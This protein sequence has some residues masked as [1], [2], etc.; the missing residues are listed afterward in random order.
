MRSKI[1]RRAFLK[2]SFTAAGSAVV[3][4]S[5]VR[6]ASSLAKE[7]TEPLVTVID[8]GKCIGCEECV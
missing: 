3:S 2:G 8:I 5:V 7:E 4:S 6:A 1:S